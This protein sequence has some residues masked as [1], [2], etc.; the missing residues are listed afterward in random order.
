MMMKEV[1]KV[2]LTG[3]AIKYLQQQF[4]EADF[5]KDIILQDDGDG[6]YIKYWGIGLPQPT[7]EE[8]NAAAESMTSKWE[9]PSLEEQ[10]LLL[11]N[12]QKNGTKTFSARI[13]A[14]GTNK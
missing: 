14:V 9:K 8:L 12:D 6:P 13:D 10:L 5:L 1:K 3:K 2:S 11:Y 7:N 4:P